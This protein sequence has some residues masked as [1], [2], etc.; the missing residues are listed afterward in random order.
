MRYKHIPLHKTE[1]FSP[2]VLDY[3]GKKGG[4]ERLYHRFPEMSS[5]KGQIEEKMKHFS[6]HHRQ[7]LVD[8]LHKQYNR[9]FATHDYSQRIELLGKKKTFTV[10]TGHQL[11]LATG[12]LYFIYK[13]A[14]AI[15]LSRSLKSQYPDFEFIP[16]YWMATEDHDLE[17]IQF[18]NHD[19]KK[20]TW[21]TDQSGPVGRM[22]TEGISDMI[23]NLDL[24]VGVNAREIRDILQHAYA[25]SNTLADAQRKIVHRL[26]SDYELL[27]IDGDDRELKRLFSPLVKKEIEESVVLN[28]S[29]ASLEIL[30]KFYSVQ[31]NPREI[32]LFYIRDGIR[33]RLDRVE[34]ELVFVDRQEVFRKENWNSELEGFPERFSPNVLLRPVYQ[35]LILP[36]LAY[37]G[38]GAE[39]A[40]W[41]ELKDVFAQFDVPMPIVMLRNSVMNVPMTANRSRQKLGF[42][43]RDLFRSEQVLIHTVI[44]AESNEKLDFT[45]YRKKIEAFFTEMEKIAERTEKTF[46]NAVKAQKAKQLK[47][48]DKLEKRLLKAEKRKYKQLTDRVT[49]L[50][51]RLFPKGLQER[52]DNVISYYSEWGMEWIHGLVE[53]CDPLQFEFLIAYEEWNGSSS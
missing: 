6:S 30:E 35:E 46:A 28:A 25:S 10:T 53:Q 21:K 34:G 48:V 42:T 2:L 11:N 32:N 12:P 9:S 7:V 40:Y 24:D 45:P 38:G 16:V 4:L 5:F 51:K 39:V 27:V 23:S 8:S 17:E 3:I 49:K 33:E 43:W 50:K 19:G 26:F 37:I 36:N 44:H 13:I 20:R 47:G 41:M 31:V 52:H 1:S 18:F 15:H 22:N 29:Q 14:S